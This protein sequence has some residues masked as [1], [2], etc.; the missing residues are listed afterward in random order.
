MALSLEVFA[1]DP[2]ASPDQFILDQI[3]FK[4]EQTSSYETGYRAGW[5]EASATATALAARNQADLAQ[6]PVVPPGRQSRIDHRQG[7]PAA[8]R[9]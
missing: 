6:Q 4:R 2:K 9:A 3:A 5:Q 1:A 7:L 8:G